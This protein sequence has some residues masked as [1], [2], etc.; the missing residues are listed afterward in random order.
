MNQRSTVAFRLCTMIRATGVS[1]VSGMLV[2]LAPPEMLLLTL[3]PAD[4]SSGRRGTWCR[5]RRAAMQVAASQQRLHRW[6]PDLPGDM[7]SG[8]R[9]TWS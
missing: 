2:A 6:S 1:G 3:L 7:S 4:E 8:A 9:K 5:L